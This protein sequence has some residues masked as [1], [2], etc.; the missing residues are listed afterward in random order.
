MHLFSAIPRKLIGV[1]NFQVSYAFNLYI[2]GLN[3][4]SMQLFNTNS[5]SLTNHVGKKNLSTRIV[6]SGV[7]IESRT[8]LNK[9]A[10][11]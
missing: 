11:N 6:D 3:M 10:K 4:G 7:S 8:K 2:S 1:E 9:W 5:L